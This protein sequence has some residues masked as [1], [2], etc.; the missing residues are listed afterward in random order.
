MDPEDD[1]IEPPKLTDPIP[2]DRG[3][4]VM[5]IEKVLEGLGKIWC[6]TKE[7]SAFLG[8]TEKTL[9][10]MFRNEPRARELYEQ[11][12]LLGNI[13][14]RHRNVKLATAGNPA[15]NI[16]ISKNVLGMRDHFDVAGTVTH[17]HNVL[18]A[19]YQQITRGKAGKIIEGEVVAPALP[20]PAAKV[21]EEA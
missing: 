10:K 5:P 7:V 6:T 3:M 18:I 1:S 11:G 19:L 15:M 17:E 14:Q 20:A 9:F 4:E 13:S 16:F 21:I 2:P 8:I 12:K